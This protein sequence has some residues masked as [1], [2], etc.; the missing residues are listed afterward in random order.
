VGR[1]NELNKACEREFMTLPK[2]F[3]SS[4]FVNIGLCNLLTLSIALVPIALFFAIRFANENNQCFQGHY[5]YIRTTIAIL[6]IGTCLAG[7]MVLVGA[8]LSTLLILAGL[9]LLSL[10]GTLVILRC[11]SGLALCIRKEPHRNYESY[12]I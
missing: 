11:F 8:A 5:H 10:T 9:A 12:L 3:F 7:L 1:T 6:V 2:A 4:G